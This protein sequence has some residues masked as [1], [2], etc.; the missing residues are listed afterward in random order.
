MFCKKCGG[1]LI[2][3]IVNGK[4]VWKCSRCGAIYENINIIITES[5]KTKKEEIQLVKEREE[6]QKYPI[7]EDVKC[8]KCGHKG[9]YFEVKQTRA[10][11]E[12]PTII[13]RCPK[14][15]YTWREYG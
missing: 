13:Y 15:G 12:A 6:I 8:P 5:K 4:K 2:P 1:L 14:C 3:S 9:V 7:A 10:A 11:D